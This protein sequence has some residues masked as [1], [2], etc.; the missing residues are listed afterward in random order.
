[1][2]KWIFAFLTIASLLSAE[3]EI[4]V[5]LTTRAKLAPLYLC[6]FHT[7][8][9]KLPLTYLK[10]LRK[11]FEFDLSHSGYSKVLPLNEILEKAA[12]HTDLA[13]A[14]NPSRWSK[15]GVSYVIKGN[16][17]D[18]TLNLFVFSVKES[19]LKQFQ[20]IP[21]SGNLDVDRRQLH[22]LSD[23]LMKTLF[24]IEG[25]ATTHI[26]YSVQ[27]KKES[28][29]ASNWRSEIWECDWDGGNPRQVTYEQDYSITPVMIPAHPTYGSDRF[30][31][32]NYKNGQPKIY[33]SS[34]K[35]RT[36][37]PLLELRGNQLLPAISKQRDK[38]AFISDAA[39]RADLFVQKVEPSGILIGKPEQLFSYPRSTQGS[40]SFS[41]DGKKL[42]FV[43][44]KDGTP[45]IYLIASMIQNSKRPKPALITKRNRENTCPTWSPDGTK[46]A[47]SAKTKGVRQIWIYDLE[48]EEELQLTT[49]PGNKENPCW[50]LNSLHL[51]FN[52]T[53]P[54]STELYLVNL[55][56]PDAVRITK[57]SGKKHYPTWGTQ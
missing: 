2:S 31:Y 53:D 39:G 50:A 15:G 20:G 54:D 42:A 14:F 38:I 33:F 17:E 6:R 28:S 4:R 56:Q 34:L 49:G 9:T 46:I 57:G 35:N 11:T 8:E 32:V 3:E 43:S 25:L 1:M 5:E 51:V 52:S 41:P 10:N 16:V 12:S 45:R 21:L 55:N 19:T 47:Y 7:K 40:P 48:A 13:V 30:L 44:D 27:M 24:G 29:S 37:K 23:A 36:G 26:L 22:K 18:Y